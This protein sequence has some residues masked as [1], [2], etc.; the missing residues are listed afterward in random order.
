MPSLKRLT[1]ELRQEIVF[2]FSRHHILTNSVA[3]LSAWN[4]HTIHNSSNRSDGG[5][6]LETSAFFTL[7]GGQ[8][9]FS[10]N[11]VVNTKLPTKFLLNECEGRTVTRSWQCGM[12]IARSV[13]K[14]HR[15]GSSKRGLSSSLLYAARTQLVHFF[16][17]KSAPVTWIQRVCSVTCIWWCE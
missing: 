17:V 15:N 5:L 10:P 11:S 1:K 8:F 7:C 14:L 2:L 16:P 6:T 12:S 9:T 4:P 3:P 13:Q